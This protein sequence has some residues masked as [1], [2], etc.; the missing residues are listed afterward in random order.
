MTLHRDAVTG[1]AS[2]APV[3]AEYAAR[4]WRVLPLRG[5][6]PLAGS[7]G[8]HGATTDLAA[9]QAWLHDVN[10]GI[11]CGD[12]AS[13]AKLIVLDVDHVHDGDESLHEL[14]RR[15]GTLPHTVS[16]ETGNGGAHFYFQ[17]RARVGCSVGGIGKGLDARG[18]GGYVV[19][20]PSIHPNGRAYAW[21]EHPDDTPVAPLPSWLESLLAQRCNGQARPVSEWRR[22]A[23]EGVTEGER[24][25]RT[26]QLAGHLLA[27]DIDPF[28]VLE[29]LTAWDARNHPPLG[30][31]EVTRTVASIAAREARKWQT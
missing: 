5:K 19:A 9:I 20:P 26:A 18:A 14:E 3:A 11:A 22:L 17:T 13:R 29:L 25:Q 1:A 23:A 7:R 16:V 15:H 28:V 27:R 2:V 31:E 6:L 10:V 24:N 4:G 21:D 12:T 30:R 8:V